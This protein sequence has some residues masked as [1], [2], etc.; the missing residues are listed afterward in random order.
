MQAIRALACTIGENI[1]PDSGIAQAELF[2]V[3]EQSED[4]IMA[5][6]TTEELTDYNTVRPMNLVGVFTS[7]SRFR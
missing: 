6:D 1:G 2:E 5:L 3:A 4:W 7:G